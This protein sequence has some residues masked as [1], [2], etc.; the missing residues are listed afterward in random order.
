MALVVAAL[1]AGLLA[2]GATLA[3]GGRERS[4]G[5]PRLDAERLVAQQYGNT[6]GVATCPVSQQAL[7]DTKLRAVRGTLAHEFLDNADVDQR[8][9]LLAGVFIHEKPLAK[10][11]FGSH[12]EVN[13]ALGPHSTV[14]TWNMKLHPKRGS[15]SIVVAHALHWSMTIPKGHFAT[16]CIWVNNT[17]NPRYNWESQLTLITNQDMRIVRHGPVC[18]C[19]VPR[20]SAQRQDAGRAATGARIP[21]S[22]VGSAQIKDRSIQF[23][24]IAAGARAKL[25]KRARAAK[26][27]PANSATF[28]ACVNR[29]L[30]E[31]STF[32]EEGRESAPAYR[33]CS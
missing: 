21:A 10:G 22:S 23:R 20:Q 7:E 16:L 17:H 5:S 4:Q 18:D 13:E 29:Y 2:I 33:T 8:A 1:A 25:A 11:M 3:A 9:Q 24:D 26:R 12:P 31:V 15:E 32:L 19:D 27:A 6:P 30:S 28:E 14:G